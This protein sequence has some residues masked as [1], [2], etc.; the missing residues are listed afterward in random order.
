MAF[1]RRRR[2]GRD[3]NPFKLLNLAQCLVPWVFPKC[4]GARSVRP[5]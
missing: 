3:G 5:F 2:I 4:L 1:S